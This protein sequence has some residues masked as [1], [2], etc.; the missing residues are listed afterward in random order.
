MEGGLPQRTIHRRLWLHLG[1]AIEGFSSS[2]LAQ[3]CGV[4]GIMGGCG[5]DMGSHLA[6]VLRLNGRAERHAVASNGENTA[7]HSQVLL[8]YV[9]KG[10]DIAETGPGQHNPESGLSRAQDL[11][12][13]AHS[14]HSLIFTN[15]S[16][17]AETEAWDC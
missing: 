6:R 3:W 4:H 10:Q 17:T 13:A 11:H 12:Q 9:C 14:E 16:F 7:G 2:D 1:V 8:R 5:A 15:N